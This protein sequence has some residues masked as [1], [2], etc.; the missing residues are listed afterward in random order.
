M[1]FVPFSWRVGLIEILLIN[2]NACCIYFILHVGH[3]V[4]QQDGMVDCV[5]EIVTTQHF[6]LKISKKANLKKI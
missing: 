6:G 5:A 3:E 1:V 2:V 4:L